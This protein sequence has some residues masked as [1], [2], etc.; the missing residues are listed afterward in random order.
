VSDEEMVAVRLS[1]AGYYGE[2]SLFSE[3]PAYA[4]LDY[5]VPRSQLER[6]KAAKASYEAAQDEIEQVMGEQRERVNALYAE[7]P[8]SP[9][10]KFIQDIY[11]P[12]IQRALEQRPLLDRLV[13]DD[14]PPLVTDAKIDRDEEERGL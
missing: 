3:D 5:L 2:D 12:L 4:P 6:W 11:A 14:T 7:R 1:S 13:Y 9:V 10:S 8:E